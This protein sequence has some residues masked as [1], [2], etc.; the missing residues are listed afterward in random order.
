MRKTFQFKLYQSKK[1]QVLHDQIDLSAEIYNHCVALHKRYY[2]MFGKSLNTYQL[3]KY[4]VAP[5]L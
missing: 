3:Q 5:Q 1:N 2:K 4:G